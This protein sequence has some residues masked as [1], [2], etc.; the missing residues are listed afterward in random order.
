MHKNGQFY[1]YVVPKSTVKYHLTHE[2]LKK[3]KRLKWP[4]FKM[5][6]IL[7]YMP[8]YGRFCYK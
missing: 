8:P 4:K 6:T 1:C 2:K 5:A 3:S 7:T